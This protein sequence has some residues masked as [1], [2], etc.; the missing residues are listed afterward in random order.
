MAAGWTSLDKCRR[1]NAP[2]HIRSRSHRRF[3]S[4][5]N[6]PPRAVARGTP[7]IRAMPPRR[8]MPPIPTKLPIPTMRRQRSSFPRA[9]ASRMWI[10]LEARGVSSTRN[11]EPGQSFALLSRASIVPRA[12][13]FTFLARSPRDRDSAVV[14]SFRGS[15]SVSGCENELPRTRAKAPNRA[16]RRW[17][18]WRRRW[19][20]GPR[21]SS[22][23]R[24]P[25]R[26]RR[27]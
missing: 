26:S 10:G 6:W 24:D 17:P 14:A 9:G 21:G 7:P 25:L 1:D 16:N 8:T 23:G 5:P 27:R 13:S 3:E 19:P 12:N 22:G 15:R 2:P 20:L 4:N 18:D 11:W